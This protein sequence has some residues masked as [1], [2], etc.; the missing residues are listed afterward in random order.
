MR[1]TEQTAIRFEKW[2][3]DELKA[4]AAEKGLTFS[5]VVNSLLGAEMEAMGYSK[6]RYDAKVYGLGRL[7][8]KSE[9]KIES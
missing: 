2:L 4:L 6:A 9:D 8:T 5:A 3:Y 1:K 7:A